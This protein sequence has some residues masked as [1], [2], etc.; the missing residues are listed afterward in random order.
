MNTEDVLS[1]MGDYF[2]PKFYELNKR[3]VEVIDNFNMVQYVPLNI[4][5]EESIDTIIQ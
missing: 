3:I 5:D 1:T 4:K 2:P